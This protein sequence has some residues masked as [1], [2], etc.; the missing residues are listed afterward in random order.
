MENWGTWK[1]GRRIVNNA[2]V[3]AISMRRG[4]W[5]TVGEDR[6]QEKGR[7][8][9]GS[10]YAAQ[11]HPDHPD[12][13]REHE[14]E[15]EDTASGW[16][17]WK[18]EKTLRILAVERWWRVLEKNHNQ[19]QSATKPNAKPI[20]EAA[21][22]LPFSNLCP[23]C[24][25]TKLRRCGTHPYL[26]VVEGGS[27][28][29]CTLEMEARPELRLWINLPGRR[30]IWPRRLLMKPVYDVASVVVVIGVGISRW[31][32]MVGEGWEEKEG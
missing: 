19:T 21:P 25:A 4:L 1:H 15:H 10:W 14:H 22:T 12:H 17:R 30:K 7:E 32:G 28:G 31:V 5:P 26:Y 29:L 13:E 20:R 27:C 23:D 11:D 6:K 18:W 2:L 16:E 9:E 24:L 3:E 8:R